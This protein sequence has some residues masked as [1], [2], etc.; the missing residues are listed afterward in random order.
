MERRCTV[1]DCRVD[2]REV[3]YGG[4]GDGEVRDGRLRKAR[5]EM[6]VLPTPKGEI[7]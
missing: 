5:L 7:S 6:T 4:N 2:V 3:G 1:A